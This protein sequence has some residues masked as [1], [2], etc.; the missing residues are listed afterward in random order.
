MSKTIKII[1]TLSIALNLALAGVVAAGVYKKMKWHKPPVE[2]SEKSR[3]IMKEGFKSSKEEMRARFKEMKKTRD[4]LNNIMTA[5]IFDIEAYNKTAEK[6]LDSKDEFARKKAK[7]MGNTLSELSQ[8]E[9][10]KLSRYVLQSFSHK[11]GHRGKKHDSGRPDRK[12]D[13]NH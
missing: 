7:V 12:H 2:L 6:I 13:K 11:S 3:Q 8:E 10:K 9:R 4:E 5:E 1:F